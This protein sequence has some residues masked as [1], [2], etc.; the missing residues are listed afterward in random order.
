MAFTFDLQHENFLRPSSEMMSLQENPDSGD[1]IQYLDA[2]CRIRQGVILNVHSSNKFVRWITAEDLKSRQKIQI[3]AKRGG[4][5]YAYVFHKGGLSEDEFKR[6]LKESLNNEGIK[7]VFSLIDA[8]SGSS[9]VENNYL[10]ALLSNSKIS[11][12]VHDRVVELVSLVDRCNEQGIIV[13]NLLRDGETPSAETKTLLSIH[14]EAFECFERLIVESEEAQRSLPTRALTLVTTTLE[15]G[16][17]LFSADMHNLLVE[18]RGLFALN[19]SVVGA[20]EE[21]SNS[22]DDLESTL[23][24]TPDKQALKVFSTEEGWFKRYEESL[25]QRIEDL[26]QKVELLEK[27][28]TELEN[29]LS[30]CHLDKIG[31]DDEIASLKAQLLEKTQALMHAEEEVRQQQVKFLELRN[32]SDESINITAI[33]KIA[34]DVGKLFELQKKIEDLQQS[35][36]NCQ[37]VIQEHDYSH[38]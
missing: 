35:L 22:I 34:G 15:K 23:K 31:F 9:E 18:I 37:K 17:N 8:G 28:K 7:E 21:S 25:K 29:R 6:I 30:S 1:L 38:I 20:S 19:D 13:K 12:V 32:K 26:E 2:R 10:K 36:S 14:D 27:D 5:L 3:N 24:N 16:R 33:D 11:E 4:R